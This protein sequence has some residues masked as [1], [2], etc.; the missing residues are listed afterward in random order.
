MYQEPKWWSFRDVVD[1]GDMQRYKTNL[2]WLAANAS[3]PS[4]VCSGEE[5]SQLFEVNEDV[6]RGRLFRHNGRWLV[7]LCG[8][9]AEAPMIWSASMAY[10][11]QWLTHPDYV[12]ELPNVSTISHEYD[13]WSEWLWY[14]LNQVNWLVPGMYYFV[15]KIKEAF[16]VGVAFS[17]D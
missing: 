15:W 1:A 12:E 6:H 9:D 14:D 3:F 4:N 16:E 10:S 11:Q 17:Q 2:A 5:D 7:Y 8:D 13:G